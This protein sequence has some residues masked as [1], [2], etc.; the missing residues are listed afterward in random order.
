MNTLLVKRTSFLISQEQ[1]QTPTV[2]GLKTLQ[3]WSA[4]TPNM[5]GLNAVLSVAKYMMGNKPTP[6]QPAQDVVVNNVIHHKTVLD[7]KVVEESI[8]K[9]RRRKATSLGLGADE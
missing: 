7:G 3:G 8:Q 4:S 6:A 2:S 5:L 1:P 9:Q